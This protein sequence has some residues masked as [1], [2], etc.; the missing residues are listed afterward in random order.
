MT[1]ATRA[2]AAR[3]AF[4]GVT[5]ALEDAT[6]VAAKGQA[7]PDLS[8]ARESCD[9]VIALLVTTLAQLQRLRRRLG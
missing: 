7:A 4:A 9:R 5:G 6:I 1:E 2:E 8:T 3:R